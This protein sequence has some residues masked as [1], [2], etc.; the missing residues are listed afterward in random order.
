MRPTTLQGI[1][2]VLSGL[3]SYLLKLIFLLTETL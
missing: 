1:K 3:Y 2:G